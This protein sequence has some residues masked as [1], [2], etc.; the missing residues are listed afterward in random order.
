M[1]PAS[2]LR[3]SSDNASACGGNAA[4]LRRSRA[5]RAGRKWKLAE[6]VAWLAPHGYARAQVAKLSRAD[7]VSHIT[8]I[9]TREHARGEP[10]YEAYASKEALAAAGGDGLARQGLFT[11]ARER[12][13]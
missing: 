8:A 5:H 3:R 2:A 11:A 6:C 7:R 12:E 9:A 13:L 10:G 1:S 4:Q